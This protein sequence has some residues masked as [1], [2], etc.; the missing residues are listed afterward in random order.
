MTKQNEL[1]LHR[2]SLV[3]ADELAWAVIDDASAPDE[4]LTDARDVEFALSEA[5]CYQS[6]GVDECSIR[7]IP[8]GFKFPQFYTELVDKQLVDL[9]EDVVAENPARVAIAKHA[10]KLVDDALFSADFRLDAYDAL[11]QILAGLKRAAEEDD[12]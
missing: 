11:N 3:K 10:A 7:L 5:L 6:H 9:G 12:D 1:V 8:I 4:L 2:E